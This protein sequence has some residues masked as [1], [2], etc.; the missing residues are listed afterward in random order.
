MGPSGSKRSGGGSR[1][2]LTT[3]ALL[4]LGVTLLIQIPHAFVPMAAT[5]TSEPRM[6]LLF[7]PKDK[8]AMVNNKNKQSQ[9]E[10]ASSSSFSHDGHEHYLQ[11]ARQGPRACQQ[12]AV[13]CYIVDVNNDPYQPR[14]F[15]SMLGLPASDIPRDLRRRTANVTFTDVRRTGQT[16]TLVQSRDLVNQTHSYAVVLRR[17]GDSNNNNNKP[18]L[19]VC[20]ILRH[21]RGVALNA[22]HESMTYACDLPR[23]ELKEWNWQTENEETKVFVDVLLAP[24]KEQTEASLSSLTT[25]NFLNLTQEEPFVIFSQHGYASS[26]LFNSATRKGTVAPDPFATWKGEPAPQSAMMHS[27]GSGSNIITN[28]SSNSR[29]LKISACL[30]GV[31]YISTQQR[32]VLQTHLTMG[33]DHIYLAIPIW[34]TSPKFQ[35]LWTHLRD[36]VEEG[37]LSLIVSEYAAD[38]IQPER[39]KRNRFTYAPQGHK[40]SFLNTC[41][42]A[43]RAAGDD[44]AWIADFDE[45]LEH[46]YGNQTSLAE[47]LA[48]QIKQHNM[49]PQETCAIC[50]GAVNGLYHWDKVGYNA[51]GKISDKLEMVA[52]LLD[53]VDN[54][55]KSI[56]NVHRILRA[57]LHGPAY[58]EVLPSAPGEQFVTRSTFMP[59]GV[60]I[61]PAKDELRTLHLSDS[62]KKRHQVWHIKTAQKEEPQL[63]YYARDWSDLVRR[64]TL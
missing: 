27:T 1:G 3:F 35:Q 51:T 23:Q 2:V 41:L 14:L 43:A 25:N 18:I 60:K 26:G 42:L 31:D 20:N 53:S 45:L 46:D 50:L 63:S 57:G 6:A 10:D 48:D 34:P 58:C 24:F 30:I 47:V 64:R 40:T 29:K 19:A 39:F 59:D 62:Y 52:N 21:S 9:P 38:P 28:N 7:A 17:N 37:R 11:L 36:F 54:Y 8:N 56:A 13:P 22:F 4:G 15:L 49:T 16:M 12:G 44:F 5:T 32:E 33:I 55:G 61:H